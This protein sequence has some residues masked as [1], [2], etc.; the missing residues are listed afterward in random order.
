MLLFALRGAEP[1]GHRIAAA[2][3][4]AV[5]LAMHEER[6]FD[7]GEHKARPLVDVRE[8]DVVVLAALQGGAGMSVNDRL[9]RL[10]FFLAT[11]RDHGAAR[12]TAVLPYL[13]YSRK[14]RR[15][16]EYD[17]VSSRYLAQLIEAMAPD[18]VL[19]L[20]V[21][22]PAAFENAFRRRAV[23]LSATG[24]F[25]Q[26]IAARTPPGEP[27]IVVMSPDPGGVKRAQILRET[28][29]KVTRRDVGFA[30]REKRRSAG[31]VSGDLFAGDVKG[32]A[33]HIFDDMIC[34]GGTIL[35]AAATARAQGAVEVH[36]LASHALFGSD[37]VERIAQ[38][39]ALDSLTVTD[40]ALPFLADLGPLSAKLRI[41]ASAPLLAA[42]IRSLHDGTR[43][44]QHPTPH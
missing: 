21:H 8:A 31:H 3:G 26:D 34:G 40:S 37:A 18:D 10:L 15:T 30:F 12:V 5:P 27:P 9:V 28:L 39:G 38:D 25:A 1:L 33:V 35:R 6:D 17:P 43:L 2:G 36:A 29:E 41:L 13:P 20:D 44:P 14:D 4:L 22:N 16:K 42:A 7:L 23:S 24:L 11:C 19:T 32:C